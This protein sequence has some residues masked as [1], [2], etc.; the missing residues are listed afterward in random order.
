MKED[1]SGKARPIDWDAV[2]RR[3]E[4]MTSAAGGGLSPEGTQSVLK[5][6]AKVLAQEP[7]AQPEEGERLEVMVFMLS[8]ERYG[9]PAP[10]VREVV[11]MKQLTPLPAAPAFVLGI[12]S[13]RGRI[14]PVFDLKNLLNLPDKGL[15]ELDKIIVVQNSEMEMGIHADAVYGMQSVRLK[16]VQKSLPALTGVR[17]RYLI[18]VTRELLVILDIEKL[19]SDKS[20]IVHEEV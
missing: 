7:Q 10:Y 1:N 5:E 6:R 20:L 14:L 12:T 18:G 2:H 19:M 16:D 8:G 9:L 15:T 11:P 13:V 4:A 3:M 17:E